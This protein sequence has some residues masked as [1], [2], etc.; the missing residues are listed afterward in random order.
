MVW[1][2]LECSSVND[3]KRIHH[4][5]IHVCLILSFL[6]NSCSTNKI[7]SNSYWRINEE[8]RCIHFKTKNKCEIAYLK[9]IKYK[10]GDKKFKFIIMYGNSRL[11]SISV[12]KYEIVKFSNDTIILTPKK[13][14]EDRDE[15]LPHDT[16][17]LIKQK[18]S[19]EICR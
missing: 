12:I 5:S 15:E 3:R 7:E 14:L 11:N 19:F 1:K 6:F 13:K 9:N 17:F 10:I 16:L 4:L 2:F 8:Q 18:P